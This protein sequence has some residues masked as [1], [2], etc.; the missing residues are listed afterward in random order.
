[1]WSLPTLGAKQKISYDTI[2]TKLSLSKFTPT[3]FETYYRGGDNPNN[4]TPNSETSPN[5]EMDY[6]PS[7][8]YVS[9]NY[10]YDFNLH[11]ISNDTL[12]IGREISFII[13]KYLI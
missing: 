6:H 9:H 2:L 5:G 8:N 13:P 11:V 3:D 7:I 10:V 1:M 12:E 4:E